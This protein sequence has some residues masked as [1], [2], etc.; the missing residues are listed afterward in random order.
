[1]LWRIRNCRF[2]IIIIIIIIIRRHEKKREITER[3]SQNTHI[4]RVQTLTTDYY[5]THT[6][7]VK[8]HSSADSYQ[9][10]DDL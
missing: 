3:C 8:P 1:M 6:I 4:T 7:R 2:I 9:D 10:Q 5:M